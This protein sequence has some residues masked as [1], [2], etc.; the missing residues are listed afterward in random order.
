M[1]WLSPVLIAVTAVLIGRAH[2]VLYVL[3]RGNRFSTVTTWLTTAVVV[4]YWSWQWFL[5]GYFQ[6]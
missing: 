5:S 1:S 3:K 4:G 6:Q 2:Y